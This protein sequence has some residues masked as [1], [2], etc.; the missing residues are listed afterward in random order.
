MKTFR[1]MKLYF[2]AFT[3]CVASCCAAIQCA[4]T[5]QFKTTFCDK[6]GAHV[7]LEEPAERMLNAG[8]RDL[9]VRAF[10]EA[11][12]NLTVEDLCIKKPKEAWLNDAFDGDKELFEATESNVHCL[13]AVIPAVNEETDET[14]VGFLLFEEIGNDA[15]YLCQMAVDP[16]M[17]GRGIGRQLVMAVLDVL[18]ETKELTLV[19]RKNNSIGIAFY[20]A[21]GFEKTDFTHEGLNPDLYQGMKLVV[22]TATEE[23]ASA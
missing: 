20:T 5:E 22:Q 14:T 13:R 8:D 17:W 21:L 4:A 3:I 23:E 7:T 16:D 6:Q 9:F 15:V 2:A 18:P 11:Y 19:T 12:Q 10:S 1:H